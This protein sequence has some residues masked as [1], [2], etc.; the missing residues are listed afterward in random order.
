[1]ETNYQATIGKD[2]T[3]FS[4]ADKSD[5]IF[6]VDNEEI[7]RLAEIIKEQAK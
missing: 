5:A 3:T 1:M 4:Q 7:L 2:M 6:H